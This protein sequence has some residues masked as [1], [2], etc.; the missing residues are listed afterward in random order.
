M[1]VQPTRSHPLLLRRRLLLAAAAAA[2]APAAAVLR[3]AVS[4]L[5]EEADRRA[6][7]VVPDAARQETGD[8]RM[9]S[10]HRPAADG[11][12]ANDRARRLSFVHTHT[13]E[14]PSVVFAYGDRRVPEAL[15]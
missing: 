5:P 1:P 6:A 10:G 11:E 13:D 3:P 2:A 12:A 4:A 7:D 8:A 15:A 14:R 9:T